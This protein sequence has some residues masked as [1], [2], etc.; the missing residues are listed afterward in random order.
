LF[1]NQGESLFP[2]FLP[3]IFRTDNQMKKMWSLLS[4][5]T[6]TNT[7][8]TS[9]KI[10]SVYHSASLIA[11]DISFQLSNKRRSFNSL[12]SKIVNSRNQEDRTTKL[13]SESRGCYVHQISLASNCRKNQLLLVQNR[14][15]NTSPEYPK[16]DPPSTNPKNHQ[17]KHHTVSKQF[18]RGKR[19]VLHTTSFILCLI[20]SLTKLVHQET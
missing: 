15:K 10:Q 9:V 3:F 7:L 17:T 12:F 6:N 16:L 11:K 1:W 8:I 20:C 18:M 4:N 5:R 14:P 13:Y 2:C 19:P